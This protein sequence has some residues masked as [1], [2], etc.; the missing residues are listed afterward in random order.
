MATEISLNTEEEV[1]AAAGEWFDENWS[2]DLSLG[3]W[4]ERLAESGWG[5]STWPTEWYG[6]GIPSDLGRI[7]IE[8]RRRVGAPGPPAG[9]GPNLAA[10]TIIAHGTEEQK[11]KY[12][13]DIVTGRV[14]WCQLFSEPGAGSDLAGLRT[15][16][17]RDGDEWVVN[18]QKI[19]TSGAH[20]ATYGILL[21][22]TDP[23][24]RKH[25][26]ITYFIFD[27]L[28]PSVD[29]R[30]I[31]EMT[32]NA[33]FNEVFFTDA[34]IPNENVLGDVNAG[35]NVAMT[36]LGHERTMLG[37]GSMSTGGMMMGLSIRRPELIARAGD[38]AEP[39]APAKGSLGGGGAAMLLGLAKMYDKSDNPTSRQDIARI[40]SLLEIARYTT[41]RAQ[42]AVERG[43]RPGP[44]MSTG[45]IAASVL[46]QNMR[47]AALA[48]MGPYGMLFGDDAPMGGRVHQMALSTPLFSIGGGT[49]QVQ[50]NIV[51]ER[52]L[53]LPAEP[54][55]DKEVPFRE[56]ATGGI[57]WRGKGD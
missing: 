14:I 37:A 53:G 30:P 27:M 25:A 16:A 48:L 10:P 34:K 38:L 4:W 17:E 22:R 52:I 29:I 21:A 12:L 40:F 51:G 49:D 5:F 1:R 18:G 7:V 32:G 47:D 23:D 45:K 26:G 6:Q 28:Q 9:I 20:L 13:P 57:L 43:S 39:T 41:L 19:W 54:R 36:T 11:R 55:P 56:L 46:V 33:V 31:R 2:P 15:K 3:E 50:K 44:E 8:E 42:A 24:A 35:W